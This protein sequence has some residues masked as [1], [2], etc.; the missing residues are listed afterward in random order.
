MRLTISSVPRLASLALIAVG[1][2]AAPA[3]GALIA[4]E[5]FD[6]P[7]NGL[8]DNG[9][10]A[11]AGWA[12]GWTTG[13]DGSVVSPGFTYTDSNSDSLIVAGNK[14][15]LAGDSSSN[16][17]AFRKLTSA[18]SPTTSEPIWISTIMQR[19]SSDDNRRAFLLSFSQDTGQPEFNIG[20]NTEGGSKSDPQPWFANITNRTG[21]S[22]S[23][24]ASGTNTLDKT[25]L[26]A[27]LSTNGTDETLDVFVN[28]D[29]SATPTTA[30]ISVTGDVAAFNTVR[31]FAGDNLSGAAPADADFD[32]IR[33]GT[34]FGDVTPIPEPAS[35]ALVGLGSL[36]MLGRRRRA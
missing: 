36:V 7:A 15:N 22:D 19:N 5:S 21:G 8:A 34:T 13:S 6:Y 4:E 11:D 31:L 16:A 20:Q 18:Q 33:I 1:L 26:V 10:A 9:S 14:A 30:D 32:E 24:T 23:G 2:T 12:G 25:F 35:L 3:S 17:L 28:P 27:R 29:L